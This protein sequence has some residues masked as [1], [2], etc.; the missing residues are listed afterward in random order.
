MPRIG[1]LLA[2]SREHHQTLV[3]ARDARRAAV[4]NDEAVLSRM[5]ARM[6]D[7]WHNVMADHC[8]REER[9]VKVAEDSLDPDSVARFIS[10]HEE[11]QRLGTGTCQLSP[12]IRLQ[13]FADLAS[14]HVRYEERVFF[15]QLQSHPSIA[16]STEPDNSGH[17]HLE[18][19]NIDSLRD[20]GDV[21]EFP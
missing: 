20:I 3:M 9:L 8:R 2:L 16:S 17:G 18:R 13:R 4:S 6:E 12:V 7:H 21:D 10:E 14:A 1:P 19:V 15:S 11:L 5:I